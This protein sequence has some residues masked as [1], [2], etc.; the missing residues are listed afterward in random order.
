[1]KIVNNHT[2]MICAYKESP[3]LDQCIQSL[4]NQTVKSNIQIYT[5]TP[6]KYIQNIAEK[7]AL[8]I[9]SKNGGSIGK[10]WNNAMSFVN[11]KYMT[12]VH[13]DDLYE[14][15]FLE[16]TMQSFEAND[17]TLIVFSDYG[18]LT[19][20][21]YRLK[22]TN[23]TI[24]RLMLN[25]MMLAN[26][27]RNWRKFIL[28][29]GNPISCPAVS[30]N[31]KL[32]NDF[33][34]NEQMKVSLDWYAWYEIAK[35]KGRFQF[36]PEIL[37]FHRIHEESETTNMIATQTRTKEDLKMYELFWPKT[38]AKLING[39]YAKSQKSNGE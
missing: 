2:F 21:G 18:E 39:C 4:L 10:D 20:Q 19:E 34:F 6:N 3:Y 11:T 12:L 9:F 36:V 28:G 33:K 26:N 38:I 29:F 13:Q 8:T 5:S 17:D 16:K 27:N 24:K 7:Y 35:R 32:L 22:S 37:M 23:L 15:K 31:L 25:M 14:P 1:M 30:Y